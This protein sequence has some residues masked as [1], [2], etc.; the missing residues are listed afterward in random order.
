VGE[1]GLEELVMAG[2][3]DAPYCAKH[4]ALSEPLTTDDEGEVAC[5]ICLDESNQ[6]ALTPEQADAI[7][8]GGMFCE[9]HG[10][11]PPD[12]PVCPKCKCG[13]ASKL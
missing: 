7:E 2:G 8:A 3:Y 11:L 13:F 10:M 5:P 4:G 9:K 6:I 12:E 1:C